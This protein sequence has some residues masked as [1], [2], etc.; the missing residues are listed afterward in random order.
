MT[1]INDSNKNTDKNSP[2]KSGTSAFESEKKINELE[3]RIQELALTIDKVEDEKLEVENQLKKALSD[4]QNL[5]RS[6]DKRLELRLLQLKKDVAQTLMVIMDDIQFALKSTKSIEMDEQT[7]SWV[8]GVSG[9]LRK[10]EKVLG[11]LNIEMM[12]VQ[13][14][15]T[16]NSDLHEALAVTDQGEED[17]I[18]EVIQPGYEMD[19]VV[20]RHAR[21]VVCKKK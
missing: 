1:P 2:K 19:G 7:K 8:E 11:E 18:V 9:T 21:V 14:G 12:N 13:P 10:M 4:Y 6:I 16:F 5:E 15:D 3:S 20:I 17:T